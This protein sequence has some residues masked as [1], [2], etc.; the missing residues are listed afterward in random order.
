[1][2][3]AV[4][5]GVASTLVGVGLATVAVFTA[6]TGAAVAVSVAGGVVAVAGG[7]V[8]VPR[9]PDTLLRQA[10]MVRSQ[11]SGRN[12]TRASERLGRRDAAREKIMWRKKGCGSYHKR[13]EPQPW[14][15][16]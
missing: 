7:E 16:A 12:E 4:G 14:A 2:A 6:T 10:T 3:V 8:T 15:P 11:R 5:D 9:S 1:M 13:Q